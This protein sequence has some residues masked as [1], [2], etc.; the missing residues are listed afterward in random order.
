MARAFMSIMNRQ[1]DLGSHYLCR[2]N[3]V[4]SIASWGSASAKCSRY[5]PRA[6]SARCRQTIDSR[7]Q[8]SFIRQSHPRGVATGWN[9]LA[10]AALTAFRNA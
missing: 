5:K 2:A 10:R 4:T 1:R 3:V 9:E 6:L 8:R 7:F